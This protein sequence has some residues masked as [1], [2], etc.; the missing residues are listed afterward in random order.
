MQA[1]VV[2]TP[3]E[4]KKFI[5]QALLAMNSVK[6]ALKKGMVVVHPSSTTLFLYEAIMG[7]LPDAGT[8]WVSG[9][10]LEKGSP[11]K[12]PVKR[13]NTSPFKKNC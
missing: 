12:G 2:L 3:D 9:M 13:K 11:I 7:R 4:S 10:I 1:E 6:K 8:H 5:I